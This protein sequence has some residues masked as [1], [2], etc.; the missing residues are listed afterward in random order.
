M[1]DTSNALTSQYEVYVSQYEASSQLILK[2]A[3]AQFRDF[4]TLEK[5]L[6]SLKIVFQEAD[7]ALAKYGVENTPIST[8]DEMQLNMLGAKLKAQIESVVSLFPG[9]QA[10]DLTYI[11][12]AK[13]ATLDQPK[14]KG[15]EAKLKDADAAFEKNLT[16]MIPPGPGDPP[17]IPGQDKEYPD[18]DGDNIENIPDADEI[19][20]ID[21]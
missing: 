13:V 5:A 21:G 20:L 4:S 11:Q 18:T 1:S 2:G 12:S 19:D 16:S 3:S 15:L 9:M 7:A 14:L 17:D 6:S 8:S 10:A